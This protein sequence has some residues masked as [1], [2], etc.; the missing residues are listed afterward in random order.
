MVNVTAR[1][2]VKIQNLPPWEVDWSDRNH[3]KSRSSLTIDDILPSQD[4]SAEFMRRAVRYLMCF[5]VSEFSALADLEKFVPP[6]QTP[7]PVRKA[8][9]IPM[10]LLFKDEKY[11]AETIDILSDYITAAQLTGVEPQVNTLPTVNNIIGT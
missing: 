4:D 1:L 2:A 3:Q 6:E 11:T 10:K 7:H 8:E 5:L 9:V